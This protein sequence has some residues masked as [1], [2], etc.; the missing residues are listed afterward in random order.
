[1]TLATRV[2]READSIAALVNAATKGVFTFVLCDHDET[3]AKAAAYLATRIKIPLYLINVEESGGKLGD[4]LS[5]LGSRRSCVFVSISD[6]AIPPYLPL[7]CRDTARLRRVPHAVMF[8]V[9]EAGFHR[10]SRSAPEF[11]AIRS[12]L[13]DL[14]RK[15]I[16]W[17]PEPLAAN[18][19]VCG[20]IDEMKG[21]AAACRQQLA[22]CEDSRKK[23]DLYNRLG[24]TLSVLREYRDAV[25][26]IRQSLAL[27]RSLSQPALEADNLFLLGQVA[28]F[29]DRLRR[30]QVLL[31]AS[32][33]R[34]NGNCDAGLH[35]A[36]SS[37]AIRQGDLPLATGHAEA[38]VAGSRAARDNEGL[39]L[40]LRQLAQC[41]A[42]SGLLQEAE[43]ALTEILAL[44]RDSVGARE[45][46]L[47][48]WQLAEITLRR[49]DL[50]VAE[51]K[52]LRALRP[53]QELRDQDSLAL[54]WYRLA[55]VAEQRGD[56][57]G[58]AERLEE[59]LWLWREAGREDYAAKVE[60][61]LLALAGPGKAASAA[62]AMGQ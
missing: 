27:S 9:S 60:S 13:F 19:L 18:T 33:A 54:A 23:A 1:M 44:P 50:D 15:G 51:A 38:S 21:R 17:H 36:L 6:A 46:A 37:L 5:R 47:A 56:F 40:G 55:S 34:M 2:E 41:Y 62:L 12:R 39:A 31:N 58:A 42:G 14:R 57:S 7:L 25:S 24:F 45:R 11:A 53:L 30:A 16:A 35:W 29:R 61:Q 10:I 32:A 52:M 8:W 49:G 26:A 48:E 22:V 43:T 3:P 4:A 20:D 59:A 28:L